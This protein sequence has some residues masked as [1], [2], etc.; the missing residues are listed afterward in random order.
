M[1]VEIITAILSGDRT[2]ELRVFGLTEL[3]ET[4]ETRLTASLCKL[5]TRNQ[6]SWKRYSY[7]YLEPWNMFQ[8]HFKLC[9]RLTGLYTCNWSSTS[10]LVRLRRVLRIYAMD[11]FLIDCTLGRY[12]DIYCSKL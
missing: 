5:M 7:C 10:G 3:D 8:D 6:R 12:M 1:D 4:Q 9:F 2:L 11:I